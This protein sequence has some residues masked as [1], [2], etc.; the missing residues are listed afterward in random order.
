MAEWTHNICERDWFADRKYSAHESGGF[1]MPSRIL[2][3]DGGDHNGI[4]CVCGV[5]T[6][7]GIYIR[8]DEKELTCKGDHENPDK[9]SPFLGMKL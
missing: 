9:W 7:S 6:V 3:P 8:E 1:R 5:P 2:D 4:C